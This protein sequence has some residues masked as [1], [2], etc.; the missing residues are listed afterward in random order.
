MT[1]YQPQGAKKIAKKY[2]RIEFEDR[3]V[4]NMC[5]Q[6]VQKPERYDVLVCPN[7]YG[8][9]ISDLCSGLVGG[10]GI[11]PSANIGNDYAVFESVHG[12]APKYTGKNRVNPTST[13][14]AGVLMLR[15][16]G[17]E[18]EADALEK[19]VAEVIGERKYVTY[20]I[21]KKRNVGTKEMADAIIGKLKNN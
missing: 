5:M 20:D 8:D 12:S 13:I 11:A 4:D 9:I 15:H 10:L 2:P 6:L 19:A 18:K 7:L 14:L 17:K 3:I 21:D 1:K 16:I